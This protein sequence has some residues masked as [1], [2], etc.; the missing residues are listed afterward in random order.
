MVPEE[1][2]SLKKAT[3]MAAT[4]R[5]IFG[6]RF[7]LECQIFPELPRSKAINEAYEKMGRKLGIQLVGTADVHTLRPG[8][9]EI[10][11]LLHAAG[12]GTNNIAA[13]LSSWEY[14]VFDHIPIS[15]QE[16][17]DRAKDAGLSKR[18]VAEALSNT[19]AIAARCNV[20]LP[21]AER[22]RFNGTE[23]D[24]KW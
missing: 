5:D 22:F 20:V 12:R 1:D 19:A 15:D 2:A 17:G 3:K 21:K 14:A 16:V 23:E 11:A 6:D 4:M 24:L 10:R 13:Q 8:Q 18:G 9:G 7:Y